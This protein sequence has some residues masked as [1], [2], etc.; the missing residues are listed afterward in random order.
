M[1]NLKIF[2]CNYFLHQ[3]EGGNQILLIYRIRK[4]ENLQ[5]T[6]IQGYRK[7]YAEITLPKKYLL[8]L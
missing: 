7:S 3:Q 1:I 2:E 4:Y 6:D 5:Y 8:L